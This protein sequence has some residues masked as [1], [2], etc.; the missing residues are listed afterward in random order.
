[1]T[2]NGGSS[3]YVSPPTVTECSCIASSNADWVFGV[4]RLISSARTICAKIGP[5][6][7]W[8]SRPRAVS[9]TIVVPVT[10]AGMRSGVNWM[11]ENAR[12]NA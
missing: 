11:R 10:S 8:N 5:F 2:K 12:C 4:A 3:L 1:M 9:T 7:N 6:R